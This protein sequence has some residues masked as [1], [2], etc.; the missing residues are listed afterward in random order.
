MAKKEWQHIINMLMHY[1]FRKDEIDRF[2]ETTL[3]EIETS[4]DV[5]K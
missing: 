4:D 2:I 5:F 3:V 1:G